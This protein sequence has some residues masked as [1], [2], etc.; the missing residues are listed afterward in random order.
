[1]IVCDDLVMMGGVFGSAY[2]IIPVK[3]WVCQVKELFHKKSSVLSPKVG[4][5]VIVGFRKIFGVL[6]SRSNNL[7]VQLVFERLNLQPIILDIFIHYRT[8]F[9]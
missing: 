5:R 7:S 6:H 2:N 1:M 3:V 9:A 4:E 8:L